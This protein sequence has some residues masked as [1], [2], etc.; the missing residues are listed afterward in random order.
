[1][2]GQTDFQNVSG[3]R[4]ATDFVELPSIL[5]EHFCASPRILQLYARHHETDQPLPMD[6]FESHET[7]LQRLSGMEQAH[8]ITLSALDMAYHA[9]SNPD[10]ANWTTGVA[11]DIVSKYGFSG[12]AAAPKTGVPW[13]MRFSHLAGYGATYYSYLLDRAMANKVWHHL[14]AKSGGLDR[15]A[16]ET[17]RAQVLKWGGGKDPWHCIADVL[18]MPEL[19][20]G[21]DKAMSIVGH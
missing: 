10:A 17:Y 21:G 13:Q 8:Q 15:E 19:S 11:W 4:C 1:M 6:A 7:S 2:L 3:T 12:S 14:F 9:H 5:M 16:G 18:E 20:E